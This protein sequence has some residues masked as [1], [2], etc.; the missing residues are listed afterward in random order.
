MPKRPAAFR[1]AGQLTRQ[2]ANR[3]YDRERRSSSMTRRLYS[4]A[5]WRR[6]RDEQLAREPLCRMCL[7]E[8]FTT[9]ATVCDHVEPHRGDVDKFWSGPFQ[10]LCK[11]HHDTAKQAEEAAAPHPRGG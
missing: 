6:V 11:P 1:L 8:G 2:D 9:A 3:V 10:S 4:T 5:A 7:G